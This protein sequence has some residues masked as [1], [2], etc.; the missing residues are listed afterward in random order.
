MFVKITEKF[1]KTLDIDPRTSSKSDNRVAKVKI[2]CAGKDATPTKHS[3]IIGDQKRDLFKI[4]SKTADIGASSAKKQIALRECKRRE[5]KEAWKAQ[6]GHKK[7]KETETIKA[8]T[9]KMLKI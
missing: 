7:E 9:A 1:R 6:R 3:A 2:G 4:I 5:A 8:A